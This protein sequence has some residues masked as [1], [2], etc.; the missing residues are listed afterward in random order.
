MKKK[1]DQWE[2]EAKDHFIADLKAQ[3]RG[4]WIVS[5]TDVVVDKQTNRNFD[6]QLQSET[7]F[8]ALEI[9]RLVENRE[10]IIRSKSWSTIANS[11][12]AE[13]RTRGIKGY[14]IH[15]PHV[16]DV[17]RL[18]IPGF[19]SKTADRLE[20]ALKHNPQTDPITVDGFEI[21]RIDDFPDVSLF[22]TGPGGALNP[23][24][25]RPNP[26]STLVAPDYARNL[27]PR[28]TRRFPRVQL[29]VQW[30]LPY[31]FSSFSFR[32]FAHASAVVWSPCK[33]F[34]LFTA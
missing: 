22:T 34:F 4:D 19:V 6:Y 23:D 29:W 30:G 10:E 16:F 15:T 2:E 17:P 9:F 7:E 12:A 8:I 1:K 21:K 28:F 24:R 31:F 14:T 32:C 5:D 13:L 18:K 33:V 26:F 25:N 20:A 3:G 11:V 27:H